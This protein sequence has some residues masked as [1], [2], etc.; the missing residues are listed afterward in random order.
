MSNLGKAILLAVYKH[1]DQKDLCGQPYIMHVIRVMTKMGTD[2]ER[3]VAV[4]HDLVEDT[5]VTLDHLERLGFSVDVIHSVDCMTRR[6]GEKYDDYIE[7]VAS[8][9]ISKKVKIADI[10]D[11][12]DIRRIPSWGEKD[13]NRS[14]K[15]YRTLLRLKN[16]LLDGGLID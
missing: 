13:V 12:M 10:E 5:D 2:Q 6:S 11:N 4:M 8:N 16:P 7:R 9:R 1:A 14:V 3:I 15:Y